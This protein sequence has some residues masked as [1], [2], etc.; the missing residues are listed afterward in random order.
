MRI[1]SID[2]A[3][4]TTILS[5]GVNVLYERQV[6]GRTTTINDYVYGQGLIEKLSGA[7][8]FYY[9]QDHLGNTRLVTKDSNGRTDFSSNYQP[10]GLQ[11]GAS[12]NDPAYKYTGKPQSLP[13]GLYYYGARWYDDDV[14]RFLSWDP[15][16]GRLSNPQSLN[17]YLYVLNNPLRYTDPTGMDCFSSLVDFGQLL[18]E[19]LRIDGTRKWFDKNKV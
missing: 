14:G 10:F 16:P 8:N 5:Q 6:V 11:T 15:S 7:A 18:S 4:T 12:G 9:H 13:T 3:N 17:L 19:F 1:L 2:G